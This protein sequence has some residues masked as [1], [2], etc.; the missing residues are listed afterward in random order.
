MAI[1]F[2]RIVINSTS[3]LLG[4]IESGATIYSVLKE[5]SS[6]AIIRIQS[7][8]IKSKDDAPQQKP[9]AKTPSKALQKK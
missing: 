8:L 9:P 7:E 3:V 1:S 6:D 2:G 4:A 5:N